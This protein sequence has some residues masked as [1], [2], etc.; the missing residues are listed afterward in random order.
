MAIFKEIGEV[1]DIYVGEVGRSSSLDMRGEC[2]LIEQD[3][4]RGTATFSAKFYFKNSDGYEN[5]KLI[6]NSP[7]TFSYGIIGDTSSPFT[8]PYSQVCGTEIIDLTNSNIIL[9][10]APVHG[11]SSKAE[12][13]V[14]DYF[15]STT[16][17]FPYY[18]I[19]YNG[20]GIFSIDDAGIKMLSGENV[21]EKANALATVGYQ[22]VDE[23]GSITYGDPVIKTFN[24]YSNALNTYN[25]TLVDSI[26][27]PEKTRAYVGDNLN[28]RLDTRYS[29]PTYTLS[30]E[31]IESL[32]YE[33]PSDTGRKYET[34]EVIRD[35]G[36]IIEQTPLTETVWTI[37]MDA[38]NECNGSTRIKCV[39]TCDVFSND[40]YGEY[41]ADTVTKEIQVC[42]IVE[43]IGPYYMDMDGY[44]FNPATIAL[45][46]DRRTLIKYF[47]DYHITGHSTI[48][49][50]AYEV[51]VNV[52][53]LKEV[54]TCGEVTISRNGA[55]GGLWAEFPE[56]ESG[57]IDVQFTDRLSNTSYT[58]VN[59]PMID[60]IKLTCELV[61]SIIAAN[62]TMRVT[63]EGE[64]FD[65]SFGAKDNTLNLYYKFSENI[66]ENGNVFG[67]WMPVPFTIDNGKYRAEFIISDLNYQ[68]EYYVQARAVDKL[69]DITTP[70]RHI[71]GQS[72]FDWSREDFNFNV[73]VTHQRNI[74]LATRELSGIMGV[75]PEG[76]ELELL[77]LKDNNILHI[78]FG[79][80]NQG[81]GGTYIYGNDLRL[82]SALNGE[83][84]LSG[85]IN[86]LTQSYD[87]TTRVLINQ[88]AADAWNAQIL[89]ANSS[90]TLRG[91]C[92]YCQFNVSF[93]AEVGAGDIDDLFAGRVFFYHDGKIT[94]MSSVS[95]S[96]TAANFNMSNVII[97]GTSAQFDMYLTNTSEA[98]FEYSTAFIIPVSLGLNAFVN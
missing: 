77:A 19:G 32:T 83:V 50:D 89:S 81:T 45:T 93:S 82:I 24:G 95:S 29:N 98:G 40:E 72:V 88:E 8:Y 68:Y 25:I 12:W 70:S 57:T 84:N 22:E 86:A 1:H 13:T 65:G 56:A 69:M 85:M 41:I 47:S 58:Q 51:N 76:E 94:G 67:S 73:P 2:T 64:Y 28:I 97:N 31:L 43:G 90:L 30:Y 18:E 38:F 78:G 91:N 33:V 10:K 52:G 87:L 11:G 75:T 36:I 80:Y 71:S 35:N 46:G 39:L 20:S 4:I 61:P 53:D 60:Y 3:F 26:I 63:I 48:H 42:Q 9:K 17:T 7:L 62:G 66:H 21:T 96:T 15:Y 79:A 37:P 23:T 14:S 5:Y 34:I 16:F 59:L 55:Q 92:L 27:I 54:Y 74:T 44:D 6:F 49:E